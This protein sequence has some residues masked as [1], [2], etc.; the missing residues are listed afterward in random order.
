LLTAKDDDFP[1]SLN[2]RVILPNGRAVAHRARRR[3]ADDV[4]WAFED[5]GGLKTITSQ[6]LTDTLHVEVDVLPHTDLF[7]VFSKR[8]ME[9]VR[10]EPTLQGNYLVTFHNEDKG[11]KGGE[12][13]PG[14]YTLEEY[15]FLYELTKA[16]S[17][18]YRFP[19][20]K[21]GDMNDGFAFEPDDYRSKC[22]PICGGA[23]CPEG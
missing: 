2:A 5:R 22:L 7:A 6:E 9:P 8:G 12:V 11:C 4:K 17:S 15:R 1:T 18:L 20:G 13:G 3:D 10:M 16:N 14:V 23:D 21:Y 19:T